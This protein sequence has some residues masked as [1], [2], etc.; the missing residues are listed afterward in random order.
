MGVVYDIDNVPENTAKETFK[1]P[2]PTDEE[3]DKIIL[4][5]FTGFDEYSFITV[6]INTDLSFAIE[7]DRSLIMK[8][9]KGDYEFKVALSDSENPDKSNEQTMNVKI[10]YTKLEPVKE[11]TN[12]DFVF[13]GI[14]NQQ[15][16]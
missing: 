12:S 10:E 7:V 11:T 8:S 14:A 16:S 13:D 5:S 9:S 2:T 15:D 3:G 1:S 4:T 6:T